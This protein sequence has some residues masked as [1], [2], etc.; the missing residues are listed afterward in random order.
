[1]KTLRYVIMLM[2]SVLYTF[3]CR[4]THN[5]AGEIVYEHIS[6]Y[7]YKITL[8]TYT[9]TLS[10]ANESRDTLRVNWGDGTSSLVYRQ[11]VDKL[12]NDY[13]K[14]T[15][16]GTHT[17]PGE[18]I[19]EMYMTD[20]NRND[21]VDNIPNSV[22]VLFSIKTTLMINSRVVNDNNTPV[23]LNPPYD[24]AAV[25]RL[26]IHNPAAYDPDGDSISYR[27]ATCLGLNGEPITNYSLPPTT[28]QA[29]YVDP[30]TGDLVWNAPPKVGTYNVAMEIE[31]WRQGIKI[32]SVIRDIQIDVDNPDKALPIFDPIPDICITAGEEVEFIV[33]AYD[34][35]EDSITL[36]AV[37]GVIPSHDNPIVV[38]NPASFTLDST[39]GGDA[40]GTFKWQTACNHIRKQPYWLIFKA[41]GTRLDTTYYESGGFTVSSSK[42][43]AYLNVSIRVVS[44]PPINPSTQGGYDTIAVLWQPGNCKEKAAGYY[45]YRKEAPPYDFTPEHCEL[46]V[47]AYTGYQLIGK[48]EGRNN[49][50]YFDTYIKPGFQYCYMM[51]AYF[52]DG[53]ESYA[54]EK[55]CDSTLIGAPLI[56]MISVETSD[57]SNGTIAVEWH[58]PR[59]LASELL[60]APLRYVIRR[61]EGFE[62]TNY[63]GGPFYNDFEDTTLIDNDLNT[64]DTSFHYEV[65]LESQL[66]GSWLP[67]EEAEH[68]SSVFLTANYGTNKMYL[69]TE[70]NVRWINTKYDVYRQNKQT[71]DFEQ[72]GSYPFGEI[73]VDTGLTNNEEYCYYVIS[74]GYYTI[75]GVK[76][77]IVNKSQI[78][79]NTVKDTVPPCQPP[80]LIE[81][82][83]TEFYNSL[84]WSVPEGECGIDILDYKIYYKPVKSQEWQYLATSD[85]DAP[86][87]Y[88]H[89]PMESMAGCYAVTAI[90][91][92]GNESPISIEYC[93]DD[94]IY[95]E[96]PN[97][98]TPNGDGKHDLFRPGDYRFVEKVE[99]KIYNRWGQLV[100]ETE[101]PDIN[102]DGRYMGNGQKVP[103]GVYHYVCDV[104]EHRLT[105]IEPRNIVGFVHVLGSSK[106]GTP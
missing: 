11:S 34:P 23:L 38:D 57:Q 82:H 25:N 2:L 4:A 90:D 99:L 28:N 93:I 68:S 74:E 53:G 71:L 22:D 85:G 54:S 79:C 106:L 69:S 9:Y 39:K 18:G 105:G 51:T 16:E 67:V 42:L 60:T 29:V 56:T 78:A 36:A 32:G 26:F 48:T 73:Y 41:E 50:V 45:V 3:N 94:C 27:L 55:I 86:L 37:S 21:G 8:Y 15:Y 81:S 49:T 84:S 43:V 14:N 98:F 102:W 33:H 66:S 89:Y 92:F 31:E 75:K 7:T 5:R 101:N 12:P 19:Y 62:G 100:F 97:V 95:Y 35:D 47:P 87:T 24:R 72:T 58:K 103:D 6:G 80:L 44:P 104:Y 61:A 64:Q 46:G 10:A 63:T 76:Y 17:F 59:D 1:M 20:P 88:E 83:C 30:I 77:P 13:D 96:L 40:W 91:S 70:E 52:P 65:A